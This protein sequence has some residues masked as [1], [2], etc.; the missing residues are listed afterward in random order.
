MPSRGR[1]LGTRV[2][3]WSLLFLSSGLCSCARV[4]V[5]RLTERY[6]P[7]PTNAKYEEMKV[8]T[9]SYL[10]H[11][12]SNPN[13]TLFGPYLTFKAPAGTDKQIKQTISYSLCDVQFLGPCTLVDSKKAPPPPAKRDS[14][15]L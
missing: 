2:R 10:S 7:L 12:M 14:T 6:D 9:A 15:G 11:F 8:R 3:F 5:W 13:F 1:C 4:Q